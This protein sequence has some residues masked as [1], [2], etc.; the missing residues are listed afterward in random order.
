MGARATNANVR[1]VP[2][3]DMSQVSRL[4]NAFNDA[5]SQANNRVSAFRL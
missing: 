2:L 5:D 4:P 1:L 3:A